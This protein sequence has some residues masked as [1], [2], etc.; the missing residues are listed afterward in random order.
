MR[1][2]D[3]RL[4]KLPWAINFDDPRAASVAEI[5]IRFCPAQSEGASSRTGNV[6]CVFVVELVSPREIH[7][8]DELFSAE[9]AFEVVD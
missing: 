6:Q 5:N 2:K 8:V 3:T 7:D 9:P 4:R 1:V